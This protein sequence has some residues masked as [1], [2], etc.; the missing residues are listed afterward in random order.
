MRFGAGSQLVRV[1]GEGTLGAVRPDGLF[2]GASA[3]VDRILWATPRL[4][5]WAGPGYDVVFTR[6]VGKE[7]SVQYVLHGPRLSTSLAFA[8]ISIGP[9]YAGFPA[10]R[11]TLSFELELS[12]AG[13]FGTRGAPDFIVVPGA[14]LNVHLTL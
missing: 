12:V 14:G 5:Q 8:P 10:G 7:S 13:W 6:P 3:G 9:S 1:W 11:R 2:I 4:W